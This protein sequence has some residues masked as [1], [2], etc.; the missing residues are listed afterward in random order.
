MKK[1]CV[2]AMLFAVLFTSAV[3]T[4]GH[5]QT[6]THTFNISWLD[7]S[8]NEEGFYIYR[9]GI[10]TRI[11]N[12]GLN[13]TKF[14]E[15]VTGTAG[16]Q[17][18]Y[19]VSAFNHVFSDGTGAIQ[20]SAKSTQGCGTIPIPSQPVPNAPSGVQLSA[21]SSSEIQVLWDDNSDNETAFRLSRRSIS[22]AR[23]TNII[24]AANSTGYLDSGLQKNKRYCYKVLA[25]N[26]A[27]WSAYTPES[28]TTT[29]R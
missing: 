4:N 9:V 26:L 18:C 27:G 17:Y 20:E 19:Q 6:I 25:A 5:A 24:L 29:K 8:T 10:A 22:P 1:Q 14:A 11:G 16:Q 28:C 7:N 21:I 23:I 3:W 15:T 2:V 13:V 12:A